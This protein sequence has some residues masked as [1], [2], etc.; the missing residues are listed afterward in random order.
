MAGR[1]GAIWACGHSCPTNQPVDLFGFPILVGVSQGLRLFQN[2]VPDCIH[3]L[4]NCIPN[5]H[6][7]QGK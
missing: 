7:F 3:V 2:T 4:R 6:I 5:D 1:G